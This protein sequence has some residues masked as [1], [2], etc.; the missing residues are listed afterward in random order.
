MNLKQNSSSI[1]F[2]EVIVRWSS[3]FCITP[4]YNFNKHR[5][6][7]K[8]VFKIYTVCLTVLV[9]SLFTVLSFV[10]YEIITNFI[11]KSAKVIYFFLETNALIFWLV[12]ALG[13]AFWNMPTWQRIFKI[14][15]HLESK[16]CLGSSEKKT[17]SI[18]VNTIFILGNVYFFLLFACYNILNSTTDFVHILVS[19]HKVTYF[20]M[21][22]LFS[23]LA[24][25]LALSIK[26][27]YKIMSESIINIKSRV[28]NGDA[29][30]TIQKTRIFF[31]EIGEIV[32]DFNKLFG[33]PMLFVLIHFVLDVLNVV[34]LM[35]TIFPF[36]IIET[37]VFLV[38]FGLVSKVRCWYEYLYNYLC[39][40][41]TSFNN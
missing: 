1:A 23:N 7:D 15:H 22:F 37:I 41:V 17:N 40:K 32:D 25:N 24:F 6:T 33:C 13:S 39:N 35:L 20:Y 12:V 19:V 3:V 31:L 38:F 28:G 27:K 18:M 10:H 16:N 5:L 9:T 30:S 11:P 8:N 29:L 26:Y 36:N 34:N 14:S 4:W 21:E 2:L